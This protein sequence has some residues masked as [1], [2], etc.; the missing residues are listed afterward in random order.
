MKKINILLTVLI[1]I[2]TPRILISQT[3]D[4][5]FIEELNNG[6]NFNVRVQIRASSDFKLAASSI[7]F[8]F[9]SLGLSNPTLLTAYNFN[10]F[11]PSPPTIYGTMTVTNPLSGV[12]SINIIF[13]QGDA[14]F[15]GTVGTNWIDVASIGF[16]TINSSLTSNMTFRS[17]TPS[18]TVVY[19]CSGSGGSFTTTLLTAGTWFPLN[20]LLPVELSAF[21]VKFDGKGK[22]DLNWVTKTEVSNYGFY[23]ERRINESDWNS[24]TF[25]EGY[26][27]SNSPKEYSYSDKDLFAGGSKFQ[28]RLKQIDNDGSFEYSDVVEV[29][30]VPDQYEL[31]QN[32]PNPFNPNTTIQ[33]SLPKQ[34][35]LKIILYN[36]LGEQ[37]ATIAEGMY[38]SGYHKVTFNASNLP[39]GTYVYRLESSEFIQVKKMILLK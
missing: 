10:G 34:S 13:T 2:L 15:A 7:T 26:G 11:N 19:S 33:F 27:N 8:N 23:V 20:N 12:A 30:V 36:M 39:S 28:Y 5:Q 29:E 31:S 37:L 22:V 35:Q 6:S 32:Y 14:L 24:I 3:Y 17:A 38:E 25:V 16:T 1:L 21:K 9:N 18:N 4:L